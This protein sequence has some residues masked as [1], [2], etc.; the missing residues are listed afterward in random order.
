MNLL[1]IKKRLEFHEGLEQSL[2]FALKEKEPSA[3]AA[4]WKQS[5]SPKPNVW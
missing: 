2:I 1:E 3:S 4:I 5:H